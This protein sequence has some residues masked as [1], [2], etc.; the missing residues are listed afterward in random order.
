MEWEPAGEDGW[1]VLLRCPEC[2]VY[3]SGVFAQAE[4][5]AY[6]A[7]LDR[8]DALLRVAYMKLSAENMAVEVDTFVT[9]LRADAIL[10]ED[11]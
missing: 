5:D 7:E 11:F 2:E 1:S 4:V 8:G 9:A 6:D 3:Q 10:P